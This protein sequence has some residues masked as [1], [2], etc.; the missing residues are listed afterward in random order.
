MKPINEVLQLRVQTTV[1][2]PNSERA[3]QIVAV[4]ELMSEDNTNFK[5]WLGRT[6]HLSPEQIY[7]MLK[8]ARQGKN[9]PALFNYLL[10]QTKT[11]PFKKRLD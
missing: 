2:T 3:E 4:L 1:K 11:A 6:R 7:L 8:N 9:P 5:K 10:K